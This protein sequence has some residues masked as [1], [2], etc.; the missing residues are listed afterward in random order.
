VLI[1]WQNETRS[2]MVRPPPV[3]AGKY[4]NHAGFGDTR[5]CEDYWR[6][7]D[8]NAQGKNGLSVRCNYKHRLLF[9]RPLC[10]VAVRS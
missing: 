7:N 10:E 9:R 6:R 1:N 2:A 5:S 4:Q 3:H 8:R